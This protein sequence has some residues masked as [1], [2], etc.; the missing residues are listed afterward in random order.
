VKKMRQTAIDAAGVGFRTG[1]FWATGLVGFALLV[2][3]VC[4]ATVYPKHHLLSVA[5]WLLTF[6]CLSGLGVYVSTQRAFNA[7]FVD[8]TQRLHLVRTILEWA[9]EQV[10]AQETIESFEPSALVDVIRILPKKLAAQLRG[11]PLFVRWLGERVLG[12]TTYR[13]VAAL[14]KEAESR[15]L[16]V[17]ELQP[18][19]N[20]LDEKIVAAS[21]NTVRT[22]TFATVGSG[23]LVV[24]CLTLLLRIV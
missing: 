16:V 3:V 13:L 14:E 9:V 19:A 8:A 20:H 18:L 24:L 11:S 1:V 7:A 22:T 12:R 4:A 2:S 15:D 10:P 5:L 6:V 17:R 23:T 21:R